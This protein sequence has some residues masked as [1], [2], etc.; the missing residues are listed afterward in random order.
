MG[1]RKQTGVWL[2]SLALALGAAA[3]G[4]DEDEAP[5]KDSGSGFTDPED[6]SRPDSGR[7]DGGTPREDADTEEDSDAPDASESCEASKAEADEKEW[8]EGCFKCAPE[9]SEQLLNSC[10]TG[11]RTFDPANYPS[12]WQPGEDLPALP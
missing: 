2:V 4:D 5:P 6:A 3:C 1:T 9:T 10:A 11:W 7:A 12:S 8:A